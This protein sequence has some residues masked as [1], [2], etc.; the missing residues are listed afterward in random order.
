MLDNCRI[1][2]PFRRDSESLVNVTAQATDGE[3][4]KAEGEIE[5]RPRGER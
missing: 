5:K 3:E 4:R 2:K 1:G